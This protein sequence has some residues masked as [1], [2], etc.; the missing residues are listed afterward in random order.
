[1]STTPDRDEALCDRCDAPWTYMRGAESLCAACHD[2]ETRP[3]R[4]I[5]SATQKRVRELLAALSLAVLA[6]CRHEEW[7]TDIVLGVGAL[8][9]HPDGMGDADDVLYDFHEWCGMC[10]KRWP[11]DAPAA[12]CPECNNW[13]AWPRAIADAFCVAATAL[14][15][16]SAEQ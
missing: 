10:D 6:E 16:W 2:A 9:E 13:G 1:M 14:Y 7:A 3:A 15:D 11:S 12:H 8:L 5:V 4:P